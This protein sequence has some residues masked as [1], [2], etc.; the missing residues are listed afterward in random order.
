MDEMILED[1]LTYSTKWK[2]ELIEA[3]Y[4][5]PDRSPDYFGDGVGVDE[6]GGAIEKYFLSPSLSFYLVAF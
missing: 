5:Y 3:G 1:R 2:K 4:R 6:G